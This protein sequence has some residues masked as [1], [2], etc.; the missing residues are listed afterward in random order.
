MMKK[1]YM[2]PDLTLVMS[3]TETLLTSSMGSNSTPLL[4]LDDALSDDT[5]ILAD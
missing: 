1:V 5:G 3:D 2:K 4:D